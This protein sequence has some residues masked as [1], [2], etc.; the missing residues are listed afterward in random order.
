[1]ALAELQG[2]FLAA[3]KGEPDALL[4]QVAEQGPLAPADRIA[5]YGNAYRLR[6]AAVLETDHPMLA[7]YLGD[8]AFGELCE[9][10]IDHHPSRHKSL[11]H[12]G[13]A[14]P[15]YLVE[16]A[17]FAEHPQLAELARFERLLLDAFDGADGAR[18]APGCLAELA[19]EHWPGLRL[20]FHPCVRVF[21]TR[22]N[23][24]PIWQALKADEMPPPPLLAP[25]RW[26]IWRSRDRLTEFRHLDEDE[27][28]LLRL[29]LVEGVILAEACEGLAETL[30]AEQIP[31]L[32]QSSLGRWLE[33]G[34][35]TVLRR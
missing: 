14:L 34:I 2:A 24:V 3:L 8:E 28:L 20:D 31:R 15:A 16:Q 19:P 35:I 11:R 13:E 23:A 7:L 22:C 29:L 18:A 4:A 5:I 33:D 17:P 21:E 1:M 32:L 10:Y 9:G 12:F 26:L 25:G 30:P 27:A 6:L